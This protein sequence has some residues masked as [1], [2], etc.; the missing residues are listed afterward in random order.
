MDN[1]VLN[2]LVFNQDVTEGKLQKELIEKGMNLGFK[3]LE[4]RREYFKDIQKEAAEIKKLV[5]DH[6]L[7]LFYSVPD[8]VFVNGEINPKLVDY[9]EEAKILGVKHIKWNIGDFANFKGNLSTLNQL[10]NKGIEINIEN[11]QTQV[12]GKMKA[13]HEFMKAVQ[14]EEVA[15]GYVY[16]LGNWRFV[17]EHEEEAAKLLAPFVT[18]IHVKD[19]EEVNHQ[20]RAVKLDS[21]EIKWRSVLEMLPNDVPVAIEYPTETSEEIIEAKK[22]LE[23]CF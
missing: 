1:L 16:D 11:D 20:K 18:Y 5:D 13:I 14:K 9:L 3:A 15:I 7:E 10:T 23:E 21:G 12:S 22:L 17:G 8:E 4:I 19:V 6:H 2:L